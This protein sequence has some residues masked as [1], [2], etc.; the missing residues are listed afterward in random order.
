MGLTQQ[1]AMNAGCARHSQCCCARGVWYAIHNSFFLA[2]SLLI[3][4]RLIRT[5]HLPENACVNKQLQNGYVLRR[6]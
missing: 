2:I 1:P 6:S 5:D 4:G 3:F